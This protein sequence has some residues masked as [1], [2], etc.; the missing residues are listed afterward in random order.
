MPGEN[1]LTQQQKT[2]FVLLLVFGVLAVTLGFMQ[3]RNG[4]YSPFATRTI[5]D[6][7]REISSFY[8][9]KTRLQQIDTD[10]DS[11]N[12]YEELEFYGTSPYLPDTDSDGLDDNVEIEQ[13]TDP[14]CPEGD[15]CRASAEPLPPTTLEIESPLLDTLATPADFVVD[16]STGL[17]VA[18]STDLGGTLSDPA[19]IR[20]LLLSTGSVTP[21]QLEAIDDEALLELVKN[22]LKEQESSPVFE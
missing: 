3:M 17:P 14:L 6:G 1:R 19:A 18:S 5:A 12:D 11:L 13:G 15:D 21:S 9:D 4:I 8:D 7:G 20:Q 10:Q 2:G 22:I 16:A